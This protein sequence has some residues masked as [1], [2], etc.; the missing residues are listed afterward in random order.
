MRG[1][2]EFLKAALW[3]ILALWT[4]WWIWLVAQVLAQ[5]DVA[6][7]LAASPYGAFAGAAAVAVAL[8]VWSLPAIAFA[9]LL[10]VAQ[11]YAPP[12]P[13]DDALRR[14]PAARAEPAAFSPAA[15]PDGGVSDQPLR[16]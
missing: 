5:P 14:P 12:E 15:P 11:A 8:L 6:R 3:L 10:L 2:L 13:D 16:R 7:G 4:G 9:C 1:F